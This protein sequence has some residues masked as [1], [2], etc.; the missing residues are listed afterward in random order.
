M[1]SCHHCGK[2][3]NLES[4]LSFREECPFCHSDLHTC[5]NCHFH[6]PSAYNECHESAA[7]PVKDKSRNNYCE[8]FEPKT[9]NLSQKPS[10][11][12]QTKQMEAAEALFKKD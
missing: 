3:I 9:N 2:K 5:L 6:D 1:I 4:K 8:Y 7:E 10:E 12:D 11:Q